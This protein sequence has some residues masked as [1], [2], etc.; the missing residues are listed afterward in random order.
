MELNSIDWERAEQFVNRIQIRIT[1]AVL[2]GKHHLVKR[3]QYLLSHSYYAKALAVKRVTTSKGKRTPGIDGVIWS[4]SSQKMHAVYGLGERNYKS[5]PLKSVYIKKYG[6][7]EKRPLSIPAMPD[8]EMQALHL[9]T[10]EPIA[11]T[12][13]D[14]VSFGFRKYRSTHDAMSHI[15]NLLAKKNAGSWVLE[16]DIK[17]WNESRCKL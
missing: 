17:L 7:S 14:N 10:L 4:Q 2:A 8:R 6:K 9:L 1:K 11:E 3:L 16:G 15:F 5:K 12:T 13:A